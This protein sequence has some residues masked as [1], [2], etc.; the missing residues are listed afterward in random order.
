MV[1]NIRLT[2]SALQKLR[3]WGDFVL[4]R[5]LAALISLAVA[6]SGALALSTQSAEAK[7]S[8]KKTRIAGNYFVPPP[9]PYTP[10]LVP[11]ALGM[12]YAPA[13][14]ADGDYAAVEMPVKPY[15][16]YIVKRNRVGT[17]P[18]VQPNPYLSYDRGVE[19]KVQKSIEDI[20]SEIS[21][22][23]KDIGKLLDL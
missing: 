13:V 21:N 1:R 2:R 15:T 9:P 23:Q 22:I 20:D 12:T 17:P 10:S 4:G 18:V 3:L 5:N 11:V 14:G 19:T 16:N 8:R 7:N 6:I